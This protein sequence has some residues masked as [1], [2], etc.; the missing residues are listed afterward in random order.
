MGDAE[1]TVM[2]EVN[3]SLCGFSVLRDYEKGLHECHLPRAARANNVDDSDES[4]EALEAPTAAAS[5]SLADPPASESS[6]AASDSCHETGD[7]AAAA[8]PEMDQLPSDK[9]SL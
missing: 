1:Y 9:N 8:L 2:I 6:D 7:E 4:P 5:V 3:P